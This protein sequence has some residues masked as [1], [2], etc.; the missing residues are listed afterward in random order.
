MNHKGCCYASCVKEFDIV[1]NYLQV[2][3]RDKNGLLLCVYVVCV[4]VTLCVGFILR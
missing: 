2:V 3:K 4:Y 1:I